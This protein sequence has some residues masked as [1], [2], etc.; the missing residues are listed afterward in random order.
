MQVNVGF[1]FNASEELA[2]SAAFWGVMKVFQVQASAS[3]TRS[4]LDDFAVPPFIP[5]SPASATSLVEFSATCYFSAKNL[6]LTR[7][8]EDKYVVLGLV[9]APWGGT[10]I[11]AHAPLTVNDSC[12]ALYPSDPGE[13]GCGMYHAPCSP[14]SIYNAMLAPISG[15][16]ALSHPAFPVAAFIW[17]QGE[18]DASNSGLSYY[19][20]ELAGLAAALR[21]QHASPTAHWTTISLAPYT[22]GP[23]LAPFRAMQCAITSSAIPNST[24]VSLVD[25]GD[26]LSPIGSVHSRNKQ[27][28][29]RR[30]ASGLSAALYGAPALP[31]PGG[32]GPVFSGA[33]LSFSP[34]G[35]LSATLH[36]EPAS[37]AGGPLVYAPP[38]SSPWSNSSRCPV[39]LHII[40]ATDCGW[41]SI[42]GSDGVAYN[43]SF[44]LGGDAVSVVLS[45][46]GPAGTK[47]VGTAWGWNAWPVVN[48]Y[49]V[50]GFPMVPWKQ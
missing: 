42:T 43:A 13:Q 15:A 2:A 41:F 16:G 35:T 17:F 10:P 14:G 50:A 24:C 25:G 7:P 32:V 37:L 47:A 11:R 45:A 1:V 3:S 21:A 8:A 23:V 9:A 33:N 27:L 30:V 12:G 44:A 46:K 36:F 38:S 40:K 6:I 19:P 31:T 34:D 26:P 18:N 22:G 28:V 4:P 49:N 5:W 20:C 39:E 29:G 48:F